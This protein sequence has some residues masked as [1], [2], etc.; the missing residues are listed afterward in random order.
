MENK[1]LERK[2]KDTTV[3]AEAHLQLQFYLGTDENCVMIQR[4]LPDKK[5]YYAMFSGDVFGTAYNRNLLHRQKYEEGLTRREMADVIVNSYIGLMYGEYRIYS[6]VRLVDEHGLTLGWGIW[7][8]DTYYI[9]DKNSKAF[10]DA[11]AIY[12]TKENKDLEKHMTG[13]C[14]RTIQVR[15]IKKYNKGFFKVRAEYMIKPNN[16]VTLVKKLEE[17]S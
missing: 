11:S 12:K 14:V 10:K 17:E 13:C 4:E 16:I 3:M 6:F 9:V 15:D 7:M 5:Q 8:K 1:T 2:F